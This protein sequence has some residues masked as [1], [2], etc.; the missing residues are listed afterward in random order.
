MIKK[1]IVFILT[2]LCIFTFSLTVN[3]SSKSDFE[4][5]ARLYYDSYYILYDIDNPSYELIVVKGL[6]DDKPSYG[7]SYNSI[8]GKYQLVL[9]QNDSYYTLKENKAIAIEASSIIY[10]ALVTED[11]VSKEIVEVENSSLQKFNRGE[12]DNENIVIGLGNGKDFSTLDV[13]VR[14][15]MYKDIII[16]AL[17]STI[18]LCSI[19]ILFTA[20]RK[21]GMFNKKARKDGIVAIEDLIA[22]AKAS[23]EEENVWGDFKYEKATMEEAK[24]NESQEEYEEIKGNIDITDYLLMNGYSLEYENLN[25]EEKNKIMDELI[26]LKNENKISLDDYYNEVYKLW[27]K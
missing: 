13:Y 26:K 20:I 9:K 27:K 7:I 17:I 24:E 16:A 8:D 14:K 18:S 21:K 10:L 3:A 6:F 15:I 1:F 12:L 25:E 5:E 22:R 2:S 4:A 11:G 19:V 23:L